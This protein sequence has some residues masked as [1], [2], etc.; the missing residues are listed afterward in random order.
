MFGNSRQV[1]A[2]DMIKARWADARAFAREQGR[3][4][5]FA[6][7]DG[8]GAFRVAPD[9]PEFWTGDTGNPSG[10]NGGDGQQPAVI[11][12]AL[13]KEIS[14][15]SAG[16]DAQAAQG[17]GSGGWAN[18]IVF[19]PDGTARQDATIAFTEAGNTRALY[20]KLHG[21]TGATSTS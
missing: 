19:L 13:P 8:T 4:Y 9:S 1:A 21:N 12:G 11:D 16:D 17:A 14:F 3:A 18:A 20:L 15:A 7:Q 5:R 10:A 2:A 6:I